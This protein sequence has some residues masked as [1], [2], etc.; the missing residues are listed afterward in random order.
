MTIDFDVTFDRPLAVA[1]SVVTDAWDGRT[2]MPLVVTP[3][4]RVESRCPRSTKN[5]CLGSLTGRVPCSVVEPL[6]T[7]W[8]PFVRRSFA[9]REPLTR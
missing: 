5:A 9:R 2:S 8:T 3:L 6:T 4:S 7:G 1:G